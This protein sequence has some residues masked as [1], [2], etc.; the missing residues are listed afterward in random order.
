LPNVFS[1]HPV[2]LITANTKKILTRILQLFSDLLDAR[3]PKIWVKLIFNEPF[4]SYQ[5][6]STANPALWAALFWECCTALKKGSLD[7]NFSHIFGFLASSRFENNCHI[8][9]RIFLVFAV[10]KNTGWTV[11]FLVTYLVL[12]LGFRRFAD[13]LWK[14]GQKKDSFTLAEACQKFYW[15]YTYLFNFCSLPEMLVNK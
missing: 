13:I 15:M 9:V 8:V 12:L 11:T 4:L 2:F 7:F 5:L 1:F 6:S 3:N 14:W 10:I